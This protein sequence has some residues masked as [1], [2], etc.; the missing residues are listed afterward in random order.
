MMQMWLPQMY[1][2]ETYSDAGREEDFKVLMYNM[3]RHKY[4]KNNQSFFGLIHM[5]PDKIFTTLSC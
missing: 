5:L 2:S 1:L 4:T 3:A